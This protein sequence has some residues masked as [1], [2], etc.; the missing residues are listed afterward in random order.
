[1]F[2]MFFSF[3]LWLCVCDI[4]SFLLLH[5]KSPQIQW[6]KTILTYFTGLSV[7]S[8]S[9]RYLG[10]LKILTV[11]KLGC[12]ANC[13]FILGLGSSS[14][15]IWLQQNS[16]SF[17]CKTVVSTDI[18]LPAISQGL[19]Q[20]TQTICIPCHMVFS[21]LKA[22]TAGTEKFHQ[23]ILATLLISSRR[24]QTPNSQI[25]FLKLRYNWHITLCQFQVYNK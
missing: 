9:T 22:G 20:Q 8:P 6:L 11:V 12:Q 13:V 25:L 4:F 10:S 18:S 5:N 16:V 23:Q 14:R 15:H 3:L 17:N 24:T 21:I 1:M 19:L 7:R 2:V